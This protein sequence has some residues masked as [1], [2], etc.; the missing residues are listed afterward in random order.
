MMIFKGIIIAVLSF[1]LGV[2]VTLFGMQIR[3]RRKEDDG[4][5]A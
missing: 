5:G 4:S 3:K 1:C 2:T